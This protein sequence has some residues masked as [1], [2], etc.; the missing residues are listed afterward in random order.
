[1][2]SSDLFPSHDRLDPEK[3]EIWYMSYNAQPKEWYRVDKFLH[4]IPFEKVADV[5]RQCHI[6]LKTGFLESFSYPPLEMMATGG[7]SVV[8]PNGGNKEYLIDEENCLLYPCGEIDKAVEKI[9]RIFLLLVLCFLSL[10]SH[11]HLLSMALS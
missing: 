11:N 3:F 6:L 9:K 4:K 8:V 5:Y 2:C 7:Y 10:V 1:M